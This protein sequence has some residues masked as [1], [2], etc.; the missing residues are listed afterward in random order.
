MQIKPY[1]LFGLGTWP[2]TTY[3]I[4][5]GKVYKET[6]PSGKTSMSLTD[7]KIEKP[8]A[9][10]DRGTITITAARGNTVDR[11]DLTD[12]RNRSS[13]GGIGNCPTGRASFAL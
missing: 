4:E 5:N 9:W 13:G 6:W 11:L 10:F 7:A 1:F 8:S 12:I 2:W 3:R